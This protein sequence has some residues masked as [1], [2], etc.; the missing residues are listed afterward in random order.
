MSVRLTITACRKPGLSPTAFRTHYEAHVELIKRLAVDT[1]PLC[2]RRS[3]LLRTAVS[4][5]PGG[6]TSRNPNTPATV[7]RGTQSDFDFEV[8]AELTFFDQAALDRFVERVQEPHVA[9]EIAADKEKIVERSTVVVAM[10]DGAVLVTVFAFTTAI[11][12]VGAELATFVTT[13]AARLKAISI[14]ITSDGGARGCRDGQHDE[15]SEDEAKIELH[16]YG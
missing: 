10:L 16:G 11:T 15:E 7:L 3:Y 8:T 1:F 9:K 4:A 13:A 5:P 12:A 6:A 14:G 2:H